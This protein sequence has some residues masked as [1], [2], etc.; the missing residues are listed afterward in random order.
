MS[1]RRESRTGSRCVVCGAPTKTG[2]PACK[3]CLARTREAAA[4]LAEFYAIAEAKLPSVGPGLDGNGGGVG[5]TIP[6]PLDLPIFQALAAVRI[7][8][9]QWVRVIRQRRGMRGPLPEGVRLAVELVAHA[10]WVTVQPWADHALADWGRMTRALERVVDSRA[11]QCLGPCGAPLEDGLACEYPIYAPHGDAV[12]TCRRCERVVIVAE[13][14]ELRLTEA[15]DYRV[16]LAEAVVAIGDPAVTVSRLWHLT[17]R[18]ELIPVGVTQP[19]GA[20]RPAAQYVLRDV[21]EALARQGAR[22]REAA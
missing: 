3:N 10:E 13:L 7:T 2:I 1:R 4:Q 8:L 19:P 15:E 16:T 17:R 5:K 12:V 21:R 20:G 18:G 22:R 9:A 14:R 6:L 11:V